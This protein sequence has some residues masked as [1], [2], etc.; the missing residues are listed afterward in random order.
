MTHRS[1]RRL[2]DERLLLAFASQLLDVVLKLCILCWEDPGFGNEAVFLRL[3]FNHPE[4]R[5]RKGGKNRHS[6]AWTRRVP[7]GP[8]LINKSLIWCCNIHACAGNIGFV[9]LFWRKGE[10][11]LLGHVSCQ[12]VFSTDLAHSWEVVNSLRK[13]IIFGGRLR[14]HLAKKKNST[15]QLKNMKWNYYVLTFMPNY[16]QAQNLS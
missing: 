12:T 13:K 14:I 16:S 4:R 5:R 2:Y 15:L 11:D 9:G 8:C 7:G 3:A 10:S 6:R 1:V